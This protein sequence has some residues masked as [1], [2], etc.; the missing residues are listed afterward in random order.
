MISFMFSCCFMVL[1]HAAVF[2]STVQEFHTKVRLFGIA[3]GFHNGKCLIC[4]L[5]LVIVHLDILLMVPK[6]GP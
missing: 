3:F 5:V 2:S 1:D 4:L 6:C